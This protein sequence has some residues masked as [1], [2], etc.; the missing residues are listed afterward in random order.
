MCGQRTAAPVAAAT[1]LIWNNR[2]ADL[3][4]EWLQNMCWWHAG[5]LLLQCTLHLSEA[6]HALDDTFG[7]IVFK[8][9]LLKMDLYK[10]VKTS[11]RGNKWLL[12]L[13]I[14]C[15]MLVC[16]L[17]VV[18]EHWNAMGC[19]AESYT[20]EI[21]FGLWRWTQHTCTK[22][23][24]MSTG[25]RWH[26]CQ[27]GSNFDLAFSV[28]EVCTRNTHPHNQP[29]KMEQ[30]ECLGKV[31]C[32]KQNHQKAEEENSVT[33]EAKTVSNKM[34]QHCKQVNKLSLQC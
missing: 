29:N 18:M 12:I 4:G 13:Q 14:M 16:H 6:W 3:L 26:C 10:L 28:Q 5:S 33:H 21:L 19:L 1:S 2:T 9:H 32:F 22:Q 8:V 25:L 17:T 7:I 30:N 24:W 15:K 23:Q 27:D 34:L 20:F 31:G 11:W